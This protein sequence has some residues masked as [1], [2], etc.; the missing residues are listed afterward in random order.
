MKPLLAVLAAAFMTSPLNAAGHAS[1]IKPAEALKLLEDGNKRFAAS[2][3]EQ[4]REP[5]KARAAL[6]AGQHP[7]T[8]VL[9]CSDSRVPPELIF[10]QGLGRLFTV[11]VAG[12]VPDASSVASIE[13]AVEHLGAG[14]ILVLGHDQCGAVKAALAPRPKNGDGSADL[15]FLVGAIRRHLAPEDAADKT[16]AVPVR[17]N[18]DAVASELSAR[19][20]IVK[21]GLAAGTLRIARAIYHL[22]SGRV[23]F[24]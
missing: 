17:R 4:C 24:W 21:D 5:E 14:L 19:S 7:H 18:V 6:A 1:T 2:A 23:D 16:L 12:E 11:R 22:D 8:I 3:P 15:D 20:K 13:Y 9:A 10:D